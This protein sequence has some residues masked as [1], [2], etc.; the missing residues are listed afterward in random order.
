MTSESA[1]SATLSAD[2]P[3]VEL[4]QASEEELGGATEETVYTSAI[5]ESKT[6]KVFTIWTLHEVS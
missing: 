6:T 1:T 5:S 2:H 3:P 4:T